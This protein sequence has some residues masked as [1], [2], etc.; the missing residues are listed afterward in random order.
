MMIRRI[1][2]TKRI[3]AAIL[4]AAV[5][6]TVQ[7]FICAGSCAGQQPAAGNGGPLLGRWEFAGKDSK[8]VVW[9]GTLRVQ[10]LDTKLFDAD[11]FHSIFIL[12]AQSADSSSGVEA[13]CKWDVDKRE[14][15]FST[16]SVEYTAILS[17][18]GKSLTQG[19]WTESEKDYQTREATITKTGVWS[20]KFTAP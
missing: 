8:G 9:K 7:G 4:I 13:P 14:V 17:P 11:R 5:A 6:Y 12:E 19:K 15:S 1:M 3:I 18:D 20:A 2:S 16:G 10:K